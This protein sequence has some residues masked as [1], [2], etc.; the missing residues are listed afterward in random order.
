MR[1]D[2]LIKIKIGKGGKTKSYIALRGLFGVG[3]LDN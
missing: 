2:L 1:L 3:D